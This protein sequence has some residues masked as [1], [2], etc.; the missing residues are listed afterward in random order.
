[1]RESLDDI[2]KHF[3]ID[4]YISALLDYDQKVIAKIV[5]ELSQSPKKKEQIY[6]IAKGLYSSEPKSRKSSYS[7]C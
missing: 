4:E 6:N 1:M 3:S 2:S 5:E 7:V